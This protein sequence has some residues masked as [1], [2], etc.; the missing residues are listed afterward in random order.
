MFHPEAPLVIRIILATHIVAGTIALF[1]VP[2][3]LA[4]RK[5]GARH[6]QFGLA[7][8]Y[9]MA[10]VALTALVCGP[11]FHNYFLMLIAIFSSYLTFC[12][13]RVLARKRP[14]EQPAAAVDWLGALL[15]VGAGLGMIAMGVFAHG[16]FGDFSIV[17]GVLGAICTGAGARSI[18]GFL[19]PPRERSAWLFAHFSNMLAA[20]IATVT[21]FSAINFHFL[22][23]IWVR[24]L[25]P[26]VVGTIV[27]SWYTTKYKR[28]LERG[29]PTR[30]L[31]TVSEPER[32]A[33]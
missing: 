14:A 30:A 13:W 33:V 29:T 31:V 4:V 10:V 18:A 32:I 25:W 6:R 7:Y 22:N 16:F 15:A 26:T 23:P 5:G 9:S 19:R 20:Y 17:L 12:G 1:V 3:V 8:V 24:W 21:A 11:Y 28:A 2:V 27:I